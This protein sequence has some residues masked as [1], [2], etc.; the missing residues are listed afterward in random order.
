[1]KSCSLTRRASF[2]CVHRYFNPDWSEQKNKD[3]FG[4]CCSEWGHG[5]NYH[6]EVTINGPIDPN[7]G[8][9]LN[10]T[11]LDDY[12]GQVVQLLEGKNLNFEILEF[13]K[14]VPT[15][16][17]LLLYIKDQIQ[18]KIQSD[19]DLTL[20]KIRLYESPTLWVDWVR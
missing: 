8:M 7:T 18:P 5:H 17:N 16:E 15:T 2:S 13:K 12:I 6:I 14:T 11:I 1:M 19:P 3:V 10:L 4:L 20:E 9:I